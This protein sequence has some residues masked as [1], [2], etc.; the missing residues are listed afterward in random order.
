ML[1]HIQ[2]LRRVSTS[3]EM[4]TALRNLTHYRAIEGPMP[5][6]RLLATDLVLLDPHKER[7]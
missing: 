1:V 5:L 4:G 2:G 6:N 7:A 3:A